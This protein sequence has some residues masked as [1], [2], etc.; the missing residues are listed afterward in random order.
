MEEKEEGKGGRKDR[1]RNS[2]TDCLRKA[3]SRGRERQRERE[4]E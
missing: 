1:E 4:R 3:N 2:Q